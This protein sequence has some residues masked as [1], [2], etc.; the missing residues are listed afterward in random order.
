MS[1][2]FLPLTSIRNITP[3]P[4]TDAVLAVCYINSSV[5]CSFKSLTCS[6]LNWSFVPRSPRRSP[7]S[8]HNICHYHLTYSSVIVCTLSIQ[9]ILLF[10]R[11]SELLEQK[12]RYQLDFLMIISSDIFHPSVKDVSWNWVRIVLHIPHTAHLTS[13]LIH[14]QPWTYLEICKSW[15]EW[16]K[17]WL[18]IF[19]H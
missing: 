10:K 13:Y 1:C 9:T 14:G 19:L 11:L 8:G 4:L 17:R 16:K 3:F 7:L 6:S 15:A 5:E 2:F 12:W 18:D